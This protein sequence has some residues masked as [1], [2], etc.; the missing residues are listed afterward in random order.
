MTDYRVAKGEAQE[1]QITASIEKFTAHVP[2]SVY[3]ALALGSMAASLALQAAQK[4][5]ESLFV[6]QWAAPFLI[7]GIYNKLV[8]IHGSD[9]TSMNPNI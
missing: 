8:K 4:K 3:L 5:H 1:D 2:S 9:G 6:G 7:L